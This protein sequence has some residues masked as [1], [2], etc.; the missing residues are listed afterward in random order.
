MKEQRTPDVATRKILDETLLVPLRGFVAAQM[1]IFALN[2]VAAFVWERIEDGASE[3]S[4]VDAVVDQFE[5]EPEQ[6]SAD[7]A[8]LLDEL[9]D[10]GLLVA[11][12]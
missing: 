7:V 9:R 6:A 3:R 11:K 4:L 1:E 2:E 12:P 10:C 5:V 8:G